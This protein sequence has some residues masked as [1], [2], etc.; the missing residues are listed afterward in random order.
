MKKFKLISLNINNFKGIKHFSLVANGKDLIIRGRNATGKTTIFDAFTWLLFGRD[1]LNRTKFEI[2]T[3]DENGD[4]KQHG[5]DH[6]VEG[7]FELDGKTL[8]LKRVFREEWTKHR[9]SPKKTFTGH[10][11]DYFIDDV[12]VKKKEYDSKV[13][14]IIS[15][16]IFKLLTNPTY[17]NEQLD[18][19]QRRRIL[20]DM[21]D[22]VTDLDVAEH[23][24]NEEL[25]GLIERLQGK[26]VEKHQKSI[27]VKMREINQELDRIPIRIDEIEL[28]LPDTSG[29]DEKE[30][31]QEIESIEK[32]IEEKQAIINNIKF[33]G[34]ISEF[35]KQLSDIDMELTKIRNAHEHSTNEKIYRLKA[36]LQERE[37]NDVLLQSKYKSNEEIIEYKRKQINEFNERLE[38][39]RNEWVEVDAEE[40][41]HDEECICPTCGQD[42]PQEQIEQARAKAESQFNEQKANKLESIV[43]EAN[44]VKKRIEKTE[45]EIASI[46][47]KLEE[48]DKELSK[49]KR[50]IKKLKAEIEDLEN[51]KTD[52]TENKEYIEKLKEKEEIERKIAEL[53][54]SEQD[55]IDSIQEEITKLE[56][57]KKEIQSDLNK[58]EIA[59]RS[60]NRLKELEEQEKTLAAEYEKLEKELFLTEEFI[61]SKVSL[62]E[63]KI[64][65][66]FKYATFKLF[67][68]QVNGGLKEVCE[69]LYKGVPYNRGLNNAARINVGLD[70]INT[71]SQHY[72]I[73]V[74][75]F[76]DNRES[77]TD[78]FEVESQV[79]SLIVSEK[80]SQL[81]VEID[82]NTRVESV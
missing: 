71:L 44:E 70:I 61:R 57:K 54:A 33:G 45:T 60:E 24:R 62:L 20:M 69:T 29:L 43:A 31:K 32:E 6:S 30:L 4:V 14:E 8:T 46:Q 38:L 66:K 47:R 22:D 52:I 16:D 55:S 53:R 2:K 76:I 42:L 58:F 74:P 27:R 13:S 35:Q 72:G 9:G 25:I 68:E 77:V 19:K 12:P 36:R 17:F 81:A 75:I 80:H 78:L 21:I 10:T 5:L 41:E 3:L 51:N 73:Q 48:Y 7:V 59:R 11:T 82:E 49:N 18:Q 39:L 64:N 56:S 23:S 50:E 15:D 40:F 34:Q 37:S 65:S 26:D 67:E 79:I 63:E 28:S 1:S